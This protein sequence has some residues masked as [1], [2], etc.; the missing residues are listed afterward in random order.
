M[1][2]RYHTINDVCTTALFPTKPSSDYESGFRHRFGPEESLTQI[3]SAPE[4]S[5]ETT[6]LCL[7]VDTLQDCHIPTNAVRALSWI[8]S[9]DFLLTDGGNPRLAK[10][11]EVELAMK[12]PYPTS[13]GNTFVIQPFRT[14]CSRR[15]SY[16]STYADVPSQNFLQKVPI[17]Q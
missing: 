2:S 6:R 1:Y 15:S 16:F 14:H 5:H 12:L 11:T 10:K 17:S 13:I 9:M 7:I 8:F 3:Q 4:V